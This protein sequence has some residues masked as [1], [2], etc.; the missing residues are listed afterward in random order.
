MYG[1]ITEY[2]R[3]AVVMEMTCVRK[4]KICRYEIPCDITGIGQH[5][6]LKDRAKGNNAKIRVLERGKSRVWSECEL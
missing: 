5:T 3:N 2:S 1:S 4:S 6:G